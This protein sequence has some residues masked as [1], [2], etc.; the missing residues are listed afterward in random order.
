MYRPAVGKELRK[1]KKKTKELLH[2]SFVKIGDY[3]SRSQVIEVRSDVIVKSKPDT[4]SEI[5]F[6]PTMLHE[7]YVKMVK[8]RRIETIMEK[9]LKVFVT[10]PKSELRQLAEHDC[11]FR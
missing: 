8:S 5:L 7:D 6:V 1:S 11:T 3:C 2:D 10:A 4:T 9:L